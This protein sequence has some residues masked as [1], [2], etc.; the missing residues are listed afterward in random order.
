MEQRIATWS[1]TEYRPDMQPKIITLPTDDYDRRLGLSM[2]QAS[3]R[4]QGRAG[5]RPSLQTVRRWASPRRGCRPQGED[6]PILVLPVV[7]IGCELS[8]T[9]AWVDWFE[10]MRARMGQR[11]RPPELAYRTPRQA[12]AAHRR[13]AAELDALEDGAELAVVFALLVGDLVMALEDEAGQLAAVL[14]DDGRPFLEPVNDDDGSVTPGHPVAFQFGGQPDGHARPA[15]ADVAGQLAIYQLV[16]DG[17][18]EAADLADGRLDKVFDL[19]ERHGPGFVLAGRGKGGEDKENGR[20]AQHGRAS[21]H[22]C[23]SPWSLFSS[24]S[25]SGVIGHAP[26]SLR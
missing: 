14:G 2:A 13:A 12:A 16:L 22:G 21:G 5:K 4:M 7:K 10:E 24:L 23:R 15:G 8:T 25:I 6:G 3:A 1:N 20:K 11:A 18:A 9:A 19:E 17:R 26:C